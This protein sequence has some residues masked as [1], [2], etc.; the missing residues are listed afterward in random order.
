V[1]PQPCG[2]SCRPQYGAK[3]TQLPAPSP[4]RKSRCPQPTHQTLIQALLS[5]RP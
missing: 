5:L 4:V 3:T 2:K 1:C